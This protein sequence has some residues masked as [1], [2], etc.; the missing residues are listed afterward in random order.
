MK[1]FSFLLIL[2]C[3]LFE[4]PICSQ[5]KFTDR[6]DSL[7]IALRTAKKQD[8]AKLYLDLTIAYRDIS[9][10]KGIVYGDSGIKI[11]RAIGDKQSEAELLIAI[12]QNYSI[13]NQYAFAIQ[14]LISAFEIAHEIKDVKTEAS[15][16]NALGLFFYYQGQ[17]DRA[18]DFLL[19]AGSMREILPDV[20]AYA[21]TLNNIGLTFLHQKKYK[22][23]LPYFNKSLAIKQ[24]GNDVHSITKTMLNI[25]MCYR[26]NGQEDKALEQL[27]KT[28]ELSRKTGNLS[29]AAMCLNAI[30]MMYSSKHNFDKAFEN[31]NMSLEIYKGMDSQFGVADVYF[32]MSKVYKEKKEYDQ[33][34]KY[35]FL[36]L[37]LLR[38]I[39]SKFHLIEIYDNLSWL[40]K[41]KGDYTKAMSYKDSLMT[42]KDS[43]LIAEKEQLFYETNNISQI[44]QKD[45]ELAIGKKEIE[46][47]QAIIFFIILFLIALTFLS[48]SV[49]V[50]YNK[51]KKISEELHIAKTLLETAFLQTPVPMILVT[52]PDY[53]L[54]YSN[55][56][57]K[58]IFGYEIDLPDP[59][60]MKLN[61][62][63]YSW[64]TF[65]KNWDVI[66]E[67]NYPLTR[68]LKGEMINELEIIIRNQKGRVSNCLISVV[69]I[70]NQD[71]KIVAVFEVFADITQV[72]K[73]EKQLKIY[74]EELKE[75]NATKDKFFSIVAH[76]LKSPFHGFLG[77]SEI[78][79]N[80]I[81]SLPP[82]R[83][84]KL[85]KDLNTAL[86]NQYKFL[87]DLLQWSRIQSG[88]MEFNP[89]SNNLKNEVE[90]AF[91]IL[92]NSSA[93]KFITLKNLVTTEQL[94]FADKEMLRL[95]L[96]NLISNAIKFSYPG[97][98][99]SVFAEE[100]GD[101]TFVTV[102]DS[103][104]GVN[105]K[106]I[107][108]LF[109]LDVH[110]T[111]K[112]TDNE[113]GTGLGLILCK[114]LVEKHGGL[115]YVESESGSGSKFVFSI[116]NA[117]SSKLASEHDYVG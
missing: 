1:Y 70:K 112:G 10:P 26:D 36:A 74:T 75:L 88:R 12:G 7:E 102:E 14:K 30:G 38:S 23:A 20:Q 28:I 51:K 15:A 40:Y 31:L 44:E 71:D 56:A 73:V 9:P 106:D 103:G 98:S 108:K 4:N 101:Y 18:L 39:N 85:G 90:Y 46:Q 24:K 21:N 27:S 13:L 8:R 62:I 33:S 43:A 61:E 89:E 97:S 115:I 11:A 91:N 47:Q 17:Y 84:K 93:A 111:T 100:K 105:E 6:V 37:N 22:D 64:E 19:K 52:V 83:I 95:V 50:M 87:D 59:V 57:A 86:K 55:S 72:K 3:V 92:N 94:L 99:V 107:D 53:I 45:R 63:K 2:F 35:N 32:F 29:S 76:D 41:Q 96:R 65:D 104:T 48:V 113:L 66:S 67:Q 5:D 82:E 58:E 109:R 116:K 34:I 79:A 16:Q 110:F 42:A 69:P 25:A 117:L 60:G 81:D 114:E 49:T 68:G 78:L 80:E 77:L 54:R